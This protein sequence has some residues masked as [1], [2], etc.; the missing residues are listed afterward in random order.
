MLSRMGCQKPISRLHTVYTKGSSY[1]IRGWKNKK[2][3]RCRQ[4]DTAPQG[5]ASNF[6][7][8]SSLKQRVI[9]VFVLMV[10]YQ[11]APA[12]GRKINAATVRQRNVQRQK[13]Q[14]INF[15]V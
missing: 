11:H 12:Q 1:Y 4:V 8:L 3:F 10:A 14:F 2:L 7:N 5:E 6:G 9:L 15:H 13:D